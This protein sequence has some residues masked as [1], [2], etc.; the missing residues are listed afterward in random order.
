VFDNCVCEMGLKHFAS[1]FL[2]GFFFFFLVCL[3]LGSNCSLT[4]PHKKKMKIHSGAVLVELN[5]KNI[6]LLF[7]CDL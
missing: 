2:L 3:C 4:Q 6:Q 7:L 5:G 1:F